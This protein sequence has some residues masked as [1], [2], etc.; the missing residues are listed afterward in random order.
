MNIVWK[1]NAYTNSCV[2]RGQVP[3]IIVNHIASARM[4]TLDD[5]YTNRNNKVSS[6]HYGISKK[7]DIHQYVAIERAALA[8]GIPHSS[9]KAASSLYVRSKQHNPNLYS[10]SIIH[11]GM[12][13]ELTDEQFQACIKLHRYIQIMIQEK[14]GHHL[15]LTSDYVIGHHQI[16]PIHKAAC[17]GYKFPWGRLY[18][19]LACIPVYD[20]NIETII[21]KLHNA[22]LHLKRLEQRLAALEMQ[23][24]RTDEHG[25]H[26]N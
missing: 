17:P 22:D 3:Q 12:E 15:P 18:E 24:S 13:G 19:A 2:R 5:W 6:A 16:D 10:V 21:K 4:S 14:W 1:G 25:E 7:G 11:E 26:K 20:E 9:I 8:N 23:E